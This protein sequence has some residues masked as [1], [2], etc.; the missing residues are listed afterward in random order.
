MSYKR[1]YP[2]WYEIAIL[3]HYTLGQDPCVHIMEP[4]CVE[5]NV[6]SLGICVDFRQQ[7]D[8]IRVI[9]P[10]EYRTGNTIICT[11]VFVQEEEIIFPCIAQKNQRDVANIFCNALRTN[12]LFKG[13][14]LIPQ[15][16]VPIKSF[17]EVCVI[18]EHIPSY[19]NYIG[20]GGRVTV[21]DA[22]AQ[23]IKLEF[24]KLIV[25]EVIFRG[26]S[27]RE[28]DEGCL[29]CKGSCTHCR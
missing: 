18:R 1:I 25:T 2:P 29:F 19:G 13:V 10:F 21:A 23:V 11:R 27:G 5:E 3:L 12:P 17:I 24:G 14:F 9:I 16:F 4:E 7:A 6:Y 15:S 8:Y 28:L 22:F 26:C 20:V